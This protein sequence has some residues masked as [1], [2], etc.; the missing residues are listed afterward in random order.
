MGGAAGIQGRAGTLAA[1]GFRCVLFCVC[2]V[3][4]FAGGQKGYRAV[5]QGPAIQ[6]YRGDIQGEGDTEIQG[7]I[8]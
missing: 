4:C 7:G 5:Y 1:F 8:G 6:G 2:F 3:F